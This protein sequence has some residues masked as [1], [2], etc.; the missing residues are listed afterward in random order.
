[1]NPN[2]PNLQT[3][4]TPTEPPAS[5]VPGQVSSQP[6]QPQPQTLP[7]PHMP[8]F[9]YPTSA[10]PETPPPPPPSRKK[11]WIILLLVV[12]ILGGAI[13]VL[14]ALSSNKSPATNTGSITP[15][16]QVTYDADKLISLSDDVQIEALPTVVAPASV[17]GWSPDSDA[18][19]GST[20]FV[21]A[22]G[23]KLFYT[24]STKQKT[25]NTADSRATDEVVTGEIARL[26]LTSKV[27]DPAYSTATLNVEN[28]DNKLEF[29]AADLTLVSGK[30]TT[31]SILTVRQI[32]GYV[33]GFRFH[34]PSQIFQSDLNRQFLEQVK[35]NLGSRGQS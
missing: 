22:D 27:A 31:K 21:H 10:F 16:E 20:G 6:I 26:G 32:D 23:C 34:C 28:S 8:A 5:Q 4:P 30:T 29:K 14:L 3:P 19:P 33:V 11:I 13:I 17:D 2:D 7:E 35:I 24:Q 9:M 25:G 12:V 15:A 1:M 18:L